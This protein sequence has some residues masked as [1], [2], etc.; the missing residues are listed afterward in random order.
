MADN[1]QSS[2]EAIAHTANMVREN[3]NKNGGTM[4]TGE[5]RKM[6]ERAREQGDN[7]RS[8]RNR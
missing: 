4:T 6:V 3:N 8:N 1:K 2:R 7:K 5:A